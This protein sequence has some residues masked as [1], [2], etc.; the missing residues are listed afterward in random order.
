MDLNFV[1]TLLI[2]YT[3]AELEIGSGSVMEL[4]PVFIAHSISPET[5]KMLR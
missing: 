4:L 3:S 1:D 5:E 2:L